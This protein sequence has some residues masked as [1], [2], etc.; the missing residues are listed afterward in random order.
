MSA[1][2]FEVAMTMRLMLVDAEALM[3]FWLV[4]HLIIFG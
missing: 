3:G 4:A 1:V 2:P